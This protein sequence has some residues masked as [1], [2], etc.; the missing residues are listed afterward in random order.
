[1]TMTHQHVNAERTSVSKSVVPTPVRRLRASTPSSR[2]SASRVLLDVVGGG[3]GQSL[4]DETRATMEPA[5]GFD[6]GT[7]RLHT[8]SRA[9]AS[10]DAI[11]A[12][13][14]TVGEDIVFGAGWYRPDSAQG[15]RLLAHELTHVAQQRI[16]PA[17]GTSI[18]DGLSVSDPSDSFERAA[19]ANADRIMSGGVLTRTHLG[20]SGRSGTA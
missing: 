7:V 18:G 17:T 6:L 12:K 19:D 9:A 1:M 16:A 11:L 2:E 3:G 8:D 20:S 14:Y 13:A 15:Q 5:L 4:D 10:A